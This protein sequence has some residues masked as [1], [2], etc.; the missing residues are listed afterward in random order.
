[1]WLQLIV[2]GCRRQCCREYTVFSKI[3]S[4]L[5]VILTMVKQDYCEKS[6][7]DL[8]GLETFVRKRDKKRLRLATMSELS[9]LLMP[10][11]PARKQ[12]LPRWTALRRLTH[13]RDRQL[14]E[15]WNHSLPF[16][17]LCYVGKLLTKG[18][19][20]G[21][22]KRENDHWSCQTVRT[23]NTLELL[24]AVLLTRGARTSWGCESGSWGVRGCIWI[25]K[26]KC[27]VI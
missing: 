15:T 6:T 1:M 5:L 25:N 9:N 2:S 16:L 17:F 10:W 26:V 3:F 24:D 21:E 14:D 11:Q 18:A 7:H 8:S 13:Q 23:V 22:E 4:V 19:R 20:T 12:P 27:I